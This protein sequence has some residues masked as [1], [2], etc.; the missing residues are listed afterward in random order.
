M[1]RGFRLL[2]S[3]L[4]AAAFA[5]LAIPAAWHLAPALEWDPGAA[6]PVVTTPD[7]QLPPTK[8]AAAELLAGSPETA[9][10]P[11]PKVLGKALD[12]ALK[13]DGAGDFAALVTDA[14]SGDVLY[15]RNG[16]EPRIP[17]SNM[18]LLTG[19]AALLTLGAEARF[20]TEVV[21]GNVPGTL[22]L[23][24]GGD[25]LLG[26]G[27]SERDK[28][29]GHAGLA[30]LAQAAAERLATVK[31]TGELRVL[32]DDTAYAG[33]TLSAAWDPAD[34]QAGEI[35]PIYP[36]ALSGGRENADGSGELVDDAALTAARAFRAA[37][38]KEMS[39]RGVKVASDVVR[40]AAPQDGVVLASVESATV[41]EH[42]N[43]MLQ[44]SDNYVAEVIARNTALAS[45]KP[46]SF[47]G[48][49]E[50]VKEAMEKLG[51]PTSGLLI[52]DAS[53]LALG[54]QVSAEQLSAVLREITS[55]SNQDLR[56]AID[57][58]PVAGL[59]GTL[60]ERFAGKTAAG[61]GLVRAKTGTLHTVTSLSGYAVTADG[62]TLVFAFLANGLQNSTVQAR[63]AADRAAA[64]LAGCGCR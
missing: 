33:P 27:E 6:K 54:N 2:T 42:V 37:L 13:Y 53:G 32:L 50:A 28:V 23:R 47:G 49:T 62:R 24:G 51:I 40:G 22:V 60:Q 17:A 30:T 31:F 46:G 36:L 44:E 20:S 41:A 19:A 26:A 59:T 45:G 63:E 39:Q 3:W 5:V 14:Q 25:A 55:G 16:S 43:H 21:Q 9:P 7:A 29:L 35:A 38:E 57:G 34:I 4:L 1:N 64:V 48:G 56:A 18:K 15:E 12:K 61:A 58:L 10:A 11:D 52:S 8:L